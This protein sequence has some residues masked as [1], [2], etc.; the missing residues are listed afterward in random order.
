VKRF[1]QSVKKTLRKTDISLDFGSLR[2]DLFFKKRKKLG[3][4]NR[5]KKNFKKVMVERNFTEVDQDTTIACKP[6]IL[7]QSDDHPKVQRQN[8]EN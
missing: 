2:Q 1:G 5:I 3:K 6:K 4:G 7:F 8:K